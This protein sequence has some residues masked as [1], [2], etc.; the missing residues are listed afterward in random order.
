MA[1]FAKTNVNMVVTT[2]CYGD[3]SI[4]TRKLVRGTRKTDGAVGNM[5]MFEDGLYLI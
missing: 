1:C 4:T 3:F 5:T 2:S